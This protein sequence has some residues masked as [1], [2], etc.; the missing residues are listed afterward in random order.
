MRER[1]QRPNSSVPSGNSREGPARAWGRSWRMGSWGA[2]CRPAR[3]STMRSDHRPNDREAFV[4]FPL[5]NGVGALLAGTS[6]REQSALERAILW[7]GV[8]VGGGGIVIGV[9]L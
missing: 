7:I 2:S 6:L 9:L 8:G 4:G 1:M 5:G 3:A